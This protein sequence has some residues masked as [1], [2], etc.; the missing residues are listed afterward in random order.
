MMGSTLPSPTGPTQPVF[1]PSATGAPCGILP[2]VAVRVSVCRT[3]SVTRDGQELRGPSLGTRKARV[4]VAALAAARGAPVPVDRLAAVIWPDDPPRD[5]QA[6]LATLASRLRSRAGDDLV[7]PGAASYALGAGVEL[8]LDS[9]GQLTAVAESRL[10]RGEPALAVASATRALELLGD[11]RLADEYGDWAPTLAREAL[12][13]LREAR[14]V[15]A[16]AATA[17]GRT[18]LALAAASEACA[19]DPFDERAHRDV[20]RALAADGRPSA[21]LA[22]YQSLAGRLADELGA[23]PDEETRRLHVAILRGDAGETGEPTPA[24]TG[25]SALVGREEELR[26]LDRAWVEA[27]AGRSSL[28]LVDGVP[29]IGKT[30]LLREV[31]SLAERSGGLVLSAGCRPGERSLFL[32]PFLEVLRPVLLAL[33]AGSLALLLGP[34]LSTWGRLLPEL[35]ELVEV[36]AEPDVSH[37]LGRRRAFDA[38]AAALAGLSAGRPVVLALDDLQYAADATADLLAHLAVRLAS[39]QVLLLATARTEG[40]PALTHVTA[41]GTRL[42][43]GPLPPSAVDALAAAAGFSTRAAEVRARSQGHPLSVVA[44]LQT[45]ASGTSGVP[46]G[47]SEAVA[48]QLGR[49]EPAVA[50]VAGAAAVLGTRVD[51]VLLGR[52]LGDSEVGVALACRRLERVGLMDVRG[53]HYAFVNDLVRDAVLA[54]LPRPVSTA[55]HRRAADLLA[56]RPEEMAGHAH[57]A[58]EPARAAG[59]YLEAARTARR[60]AALGD[61]LALLSLALADA[62]TADDP[63]LMVTVLLETA[64]AHEASAAYVAA[65]EDA[66]EARVLLAGHPEPRLEMRSLRLLGGDLSIGCGRPLDDVVAYNRAGLELAGR[67]GDTV[68]AAVFRTRIVVLECSRLRLATAH[69]LALA[70]VA[71]ARASR[72]QGALVRALDGLKTVLSHLG[73]TDGLATVVAELLDLIDRMDLWFLRQWAVL[74]SALVP[75]AAGDWGAALSTVDVALRLN[76]ETGYDAFAG[77]FRAQRAWLA[78]LAGDLDSAL[79]DGRAAVAQAS[80][81]AH[82]WWHATAVGVHATTLLDLGRGDEAAALCR[83]ALATLSPEAAPA[84]RLRCLAPLAAATGDGLEETVRLLAGV[85]T[86]PGHGWL[87]GAD[88]YE[89]VAAAWSSLGEHERARAAVAP[90][91]D[92]VGGGRWDAVHLRLRQ[93][94]S[95]SSAAAVEAPSEGTGR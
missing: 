17:V 9:A 22:A 6:N 23:D 42:S 60:A 73:E 5:P 91:L 29:G 34:H 36:P 65:E 19:V 61:A 13:S 31:T 26:V 66:L 71:D 74:E 83:T 33:P 55:Y 30:R 38:V 11:G 16:R 95:A 3:L 88:V 8:D 32:Q 58:G 59:G 52:L 64:R 40:L 93:R 46:E 43:L 14:H 41:I 10:R 69:R 86:A 82:P 77:F 15:L 78:R 39:A 54:T 45:L 63:A 49:L 53:E 76:R 35:S 24:S 68:A 50:D 20:M 62:R 51:P 12:E 94:S 90:L 87:L 2:G 1:R 27:S 28:V 25:S 84:Y 70:G 85:A 92:A 4:L 57:E 56:D 75:A 81:V 79:A 21:A 37:E 72:S 44:S 67:Q 89:C 80:P 18:D 48:G 47:I 7:A